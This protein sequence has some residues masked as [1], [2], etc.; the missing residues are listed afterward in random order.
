[1]ERGDTIVNRQ[2]VTG[3]IRFAEVQYSDETRLFLTEKLQV[4]QVPTLQVYTHGKYKV[5]EQSGM[6]NTKDLIQTLDSLAEKSADE[7]LEFA[8]SVDDGVLEMAIEDSFFDSP[9]FLNEEW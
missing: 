5:F 6:T 4:R 3:S 7:L 1:M 2:K 8:E 9:D